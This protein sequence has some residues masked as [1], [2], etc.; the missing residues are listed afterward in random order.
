M[1][2]AKSLA[3]AELFCDKQSIAL[4]GDTEHINKPGNPGNF[5]ALLKLL[6]THDEILRNHLQAP[7]MQN[8]TYISLRTQNGLI[9]TM[10]DQI[11]QGKV[12]DIMLHHFSR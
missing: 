3:N 5:L 6:S 11:F 12:D 4:C 9:E 7:A 2:N 8:A 1:L 10:G